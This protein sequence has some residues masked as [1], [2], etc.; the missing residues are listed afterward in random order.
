MEL[1][2]V[3]FWVL[4]LF[5]D[6]M[7]KSSYLWCFECFCVYFVHFQGVLDEGVLVVGRYFGMLYE[8]VEIEWLFKQLFR[9]ELDF[10]I[11]FLTQVQLPSLVRRDQVDGQLSTVIVLADNGQLDRVIEHVSE[12]LGGEE[13]PADERVLWWVPEGIFLLLQGGDESSLEIGL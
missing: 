7:L 5:R 3:E 1:D 8:Q 11:D 10:I 12:S 2:V 6:L 13:A 4:C 9:F